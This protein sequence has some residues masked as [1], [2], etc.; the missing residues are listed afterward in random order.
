MHKCQ[1]GVNIHY[2]G[3]FV[4]CRIIV[5]SGRK[6]ENAP[7]ENPPNGGF[8][9]FS[10][11]DHSPRH[12]KVRHFSCVV[13][14]LIYA[15]SYKR[16]FGAKTRNVATRKL[17]KSDF[18]GFSHG[19]LSPRQA[20][21][22]QTVAENSTHGMS[23]TFVWRGERSPCENTIKSSFGGFARGDLSRFRLCL[24]YLRLAGRKVATR[25]HAKW[26]FWRVFSWRPY[27]PPGKDT[28]NRRRK[29]RRRMKSVVLS[30]GG[31][32]GRHAKTRKS[33]H[34]AG[35]RVTLFRLFAPKTR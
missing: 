34:L 26:W 14:W 5:F 29:L 31:A 33:H 4:L 13:W 11:G 6:G 8:F 24:S 27:A 35:F 18:V 25:K 16:V 30:C 32:K 20:K 7:R 9:V 28:T 21:I 19:E 23:R 3:W 12:T 17:A 22:R 2:G 15:I 1:V 10:H